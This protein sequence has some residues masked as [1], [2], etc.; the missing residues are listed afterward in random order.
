MNYLENYEINI[1]HCARFMSQARAM[2]WMA[3]RHAEY[4]KLMDSIRTII[5]RVMG[6]EAG[7]RKKAM[8]YA[9]IIEGSEQFT[10]LQTEAKKI[11]PVE[12]DENSMLIDFDTYLKIRAVIRHASC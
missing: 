2:K 11:G 10:K 6:C 12:V 9:K 8:E 4:T 3:K 5:A 7:L 1:Y